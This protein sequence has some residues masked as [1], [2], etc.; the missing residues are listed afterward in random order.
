MRVVCVDD[1]RREE[2]Y[3]C[4]QLQPALEKG[5]IYT[6][7]WQGIS[8]FQDVNHISRGMSYRLEEVARQDDYPWCAKRF[9][10]IDESK[11]DCLREHLT[12]VPKSVKEDA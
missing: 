8:I 10:P 2:V 6:V 1:S 7:R 9:R 3:G 12:K 5:R 4:G 11:I